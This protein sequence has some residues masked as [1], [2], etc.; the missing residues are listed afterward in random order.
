MRRGLN[1]SNVHP[2]LFC[3]EREISGRRQWVVVAVTDA[4][5]RRITP[6]DPLPNS[7]EWP[8]LELRTRMERK[9]SVETCGEVGRWRAG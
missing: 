7:A 1:W 8:G 3:Q 6:P 5:S 4:G 2:F 9:A